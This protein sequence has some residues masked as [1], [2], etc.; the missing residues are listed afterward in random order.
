[1][2]MIH[3]KTKYPSSFD[4]LL[5]LWE[6]YP[7]Y[8]EAATFTTLDEILAEHESYQ[9]DFTDEL[10]NEYEANGYDKF[11]IQLSWADLPYR[12]ATKSL[13]EKNGKFKDNYYVKEFMDQFSG[14]DTD[15]KAVFV[16]PE[17]FVSQFFV[18]TEVCRKA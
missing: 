5:M 17:S 7:Q 4:R 8:H 3:E 16:F 2:Y 9:K 13:V 18:V 11:L 10:R 15:T 6:K 12:Y 1:M 14:I